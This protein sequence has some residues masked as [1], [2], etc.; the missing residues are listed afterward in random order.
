MPEKDNRTYYPFIAKKEKLYITDSVWRPTLEEHIHDF[1]ELVCITGGCGTHC[2]NGNN[3]TVRRGDIFLIDYNV[4]HNLTAITEPFTWINCIFRPEYH[5]GNIPE[6]KSAAEMLKYII[7]NNF[8]NISN[9][10]NLNTNLATG[11]DYTFIF[12]DMLHEYSQYRADSEKILENYLIILLTKL[13]RHIYFE[14]LCQKPNRDNMVSDAL[15]RIEKSF[16]KDIC[17]K[18]IAVEY[19][20]SPSVFSEEFKRKT[21][22]SFREYV[23][24]RRIN[25]AC[26]LL[27]TTNLTVGEIQNNIGYADSKAFFKAFRKYTSLTPKEYRLQHRT[28]GENIHESE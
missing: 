6:H 11:S 12:E 7:K 28:D 1:V 23:T 25:E 20:V 16:L 9:S 14:T 10:F 18:E 5:Y 15:R 13:A 27:I 22:I 17:A 2:I 19:L 8:G 4:R 26:E 21:G 3:I 24:K